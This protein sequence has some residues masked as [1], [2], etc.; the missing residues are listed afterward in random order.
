MRALPFLL[1]PL[2]L[3]GCQYWVTGHTEDYGAVFFGTGHL[4]P[5]TSKSTAEVK[6]DDPPLT[7]KGGT[8]PTEQKPG[9]IGSLSKLELTCSDN[10]KITGQTVVETLEGGSGHGQDDCGNK[11]VL[12]WALD[13]AYMEKMRDQYRETRKEK[14]AVVNDKCESQA[15]APPHRDPL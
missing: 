14:K 13:Q 5:V 12:V 10:R 1:A 11:F 8:E 7:C 15:G 4:D 2:L 6:V 3:T 9:I